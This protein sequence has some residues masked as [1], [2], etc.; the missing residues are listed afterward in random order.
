MFLSLPFAFCECVHKNFIQKSMHALPTFPLSWHALQCSQRRRGRSP[1]KEMRKSLKVF[2]SLRAPKWAY[3]GFYSFKKRLL[4]MKSC[5]NSPTAHTPHM[6][7]KLFVVLI[8]WF[9]RN[10][11]IHVVICHQKLI[12]SLEEIPKENFLSGSGRWSEK[13]LKISKPKK[14]AKKI[15]KFLPLQKIVS[16]PF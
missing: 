1:W 8:L 10:L 4:L 11:I 13:M 15:R 6:R 9:I 7:N 2:I 14:W 12:S 3:N 5:W 16:N